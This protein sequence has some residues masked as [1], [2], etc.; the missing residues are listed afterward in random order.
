MK[1]MNHGVWGDIYFVDVMFW[2]KQYFPGAMK[3]NLVYKNQ[4]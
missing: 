3:K 1:K 4:G 2:W